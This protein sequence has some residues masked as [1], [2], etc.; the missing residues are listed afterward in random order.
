[1]AS[2]TVR[3]D[4]KG[5]YINAHGWIVRPTLHTTNAR[6]GMKVDLVGGNDPVGLHFGTVKFPTGLI[7][8]WTI[9]HSETAESRNR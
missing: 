1:M 2:R 8:R 9:R 7:E 3:E 6:K 5:L 4:G